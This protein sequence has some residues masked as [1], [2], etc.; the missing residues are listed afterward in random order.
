MPYKR[1]LGP[2]G[3]FL[4]PKFC[5]I[6]EIPSFSRA[7]GLALIEV[8]GDLAADL[9]KSPSPQARQVLISS[10]RFAGRPPV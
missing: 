5:L 4:S 10:L 2:P 7:T 9:Q 6:T 1:F 3:H 8:G